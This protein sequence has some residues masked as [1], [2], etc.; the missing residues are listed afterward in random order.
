MVVEIVES[1]CVAE[2][3]TDATGAS[4]DRFAMRH[5]VLYLGSFGALEVVGAAAALWPAQPTL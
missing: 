2:L 4:K 5:F 3:T 1:D